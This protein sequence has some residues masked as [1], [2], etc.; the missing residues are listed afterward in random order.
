MKK[1]RR[2]GFCLITVGILL[3]VL[4]ACNPQSNKESP[5]SITPS[6]DVNSVE[7]EKEQ[8]GEYSDVKNDSNESN[9]TS[10][11]TK[12]TDD[13]SILLPEDSGNEFSKTNSPSADSK[14]NSQNIGSSSVTQQG[15]DKDPA[16][17]ADLD[18][19]EVSE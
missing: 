7:E 5:A 16:Y 12:K 8:E 4:V 14:R 10:G 2:I 13:G 18:G 19:E 11:M 3:F 17:N 15:T 1:Y 6:V 9:V